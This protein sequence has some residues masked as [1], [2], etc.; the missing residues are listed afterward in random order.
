[1]CQVNRHVMIPTINSAKLWRSLQADERKL[2]L[3]QSTAL[4]HEFGAVI[5]SDFLPQ[6]FKLDEAQKILLEIVD[7]LGK[8][9]EHDRNKKRVWDIR[10]TEEV[11]SI[12]TY[13]QHDGEAILH[14]DSQYR[15]KPEE[16]FALLCIR[17]AECGG[18][19]SIALHA[20]TIVEELRR[21]P[22]GERA[23]KILREVNFPFA[24][25]TIFNQHAGSEAEW[26]EAPILVGEN[27][28]Y[29]YDTLRKG[30]KVANRELSGE[31]KA[32]IELLE[33][34]I[35]NKEVCEFFMLEPGDLLFCDNQ[36][37]LHGRTAF[38]DH[39]RHLLRTRFNW[40]SH[41]Q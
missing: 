38:T 40:H 8:P 7:F 34:I 22:F 2:I 14:T 10:K 39:R 12:P 36:R 19:E 37:L 31:E 20:N 33:S 21:K 26:I 5:W 16:A 6:G 30:L 23:E 25:P 29:R 15:S 32:A 18:G 11:S 9:I 13:S 41:S 35:A 28:R 24:V 1:M 4:I 3:D 27:I 17:K